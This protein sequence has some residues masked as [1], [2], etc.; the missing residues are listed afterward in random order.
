MKRAVILHGTNGD[1]SKSGWQRWLKNEL[2][3]AGY[4]VFFPHLPDS[5]RPDLEKYDKFLQD[6]GWDFSD[7][8]VIGHS[9]GSTALLH[10]LSQGW[11]PH[12]RA[13][14][15]VGTFLN[16]RKLH[17][18]EWYAPGQFDAL[19]VDEFEPGNIAKKAD[20]FYFVHGDDDP[21]CDYDEA[22][23]FCEKVG[24]TFITVPGGGHISSSS[25]AE[26]LPELTDRLIQDGLL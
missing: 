21:Y 24:G 26:G 13:A 4:K 25:R 11:F 16:E 6:S 9:S 12:I 17:G 1:P 3:S 22:R 23:E 2:Q 15:L 20:A 5:N 7:N 18:V 10:L 8:I 14:V 19:F